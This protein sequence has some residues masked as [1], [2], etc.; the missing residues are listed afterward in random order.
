MPKAED[1]KVLQISP[2]LLTELDKQRAYLVRM[3]LQQ[4]PCPF[5]ATP[6]DQYE[7]SEDRYSVEN[8]HR[9]DDYRC[10]NC[11]A[12]LLFVLPLFGGGAWFWMPGRHQMR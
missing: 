5:C 7:A 8:E 6:L 9:D 11:Q 2:L 12:A 3:A 1:M 10:P 4:S